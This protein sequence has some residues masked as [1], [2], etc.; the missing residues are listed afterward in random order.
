MKTAAGKKTLEKRNKARKPFSGHIFFASK[1][2]FYEGRL[3]NYNQSG[4]F[5]ETN[6]SLSIGEII[7]VA[8]PYVNEKHAKYQGQILWR[9]HRGFGVE[10]FKKRDAW[11]GGRRLYKGK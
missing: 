1:R 5:I 4:L 6:A 9:N 3:K 8:L 2:K 10:L 11:N 7:T